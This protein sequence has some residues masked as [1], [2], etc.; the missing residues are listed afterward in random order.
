MALELKN[1][2]AKNVRASAGSRVKIRGAIWKVQR[3]EKDGAANF[4]HCLGISGI[5]KG[6]SSTFIDRLEPD[7]E[8]LK[9]ENLTLLPDTSS[10]FRDTKIYLEA[11]FRNVPPTVQESLV[12]G[13][14]AIDDLKFQHMPV[15][16]VL[17]QPR[18][19]LLIADDVGLGK[20]LEAGL[21]ASELILRHRAERILVVST[22]AMLNQF[23]REFWTRFSIPLARLDSAAIKRMHNSIPNN[24]NVF[25]Q[26]NRVIVSVDTLKRD[27]KYRVDLENSRW[28]LIIIDEAHN[29]ANRKS[30]SG[31]R[32]QRAKL[33]K[34]LAAQTDAL[35][36]LTATPHD[37]SSQ[38][39]A[40]LIEMLDPTRVPDPDS[41]KRADIEDLVVRRFR[42][43]V[44]ADFRDQV[45]PRILKPRHF[46]LSKEEDAAYEYV[47]ALKLDFD[48]EA[49]S[50]RKALHLF[51]TTLAKALF[52]S[53]MACLETVSGRLKR[54][55]SGRAKGTQADKDKLEVLRDLLE[56]IGVA[57]F[58]KY[59]NLSELLQELHWT[60]RKSKDRLVIFSERLK[61]LDWLKKQ[62]VADFSLDD[63]AIGKIDGASV[64]ADE[65][66]QQVLESFGQERSKLRILLASDMAS[67]GLNLHF[68]CHRLIHFDLPWS[69]LRFQQRNGR[70]DRYGQA[71]RPEIYYFIGK[72]TH[73]RVND[74]WVLDK[75]VEKDKQAQ[76]GIGD[77]AVFLGS[78][79]IEGEEEEV[80]AAVAKGIGEKAFEE[81][82][83]ARASKQRESLIP[84]EWG[85]LFEGYEGLENDLPNGSRATTNF[86]LPR[87]FATTFAFATDLLN[88]LSEK[89]EIQHLDV[90]PS[91]R[92]I[93]FNLPD[94]L[95]ATDAFGYSDA[96][97]VDDRYMPREALGTGKWIELT[98]DPKLVTT[99]IE[100]A[101]MSESA[102]P[103]LQYLW[104][105]HPIMQWFG[106]QAE[107][108]YTHGVAPLCDVKSE[109]ERD[110]IAVLVHGTLMNQH[111][112]V[113]R[114]LWNV[115][116]VK[117]E[118]VVRIDHDVNGFLGR[119][120]FRG[121]TPN[122][123]RA[124][125]VPSSNILEVAVQAFQKVLH[126]AR[127]AEQR[128]R[129][130]VASEIR[131][132]LTGFKYRFDEQLSLDFGDDESG[133]GTWLPV[134][135]KLGRKA[136][137]KR[138][139]EEM[140]KRWE[141]WIEANCSLDDEPYPHV[142]IKAVFR[143]GEHGV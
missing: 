131:S 24:Y 116:I 92:I 38:S 57:E 143:A 105:V 36:L 40:S 95:C 26:F 21:I 67:E 16:M 48:S 121:D 85:S 56:M 125:T 82:M 31:S 73:E 45:P 50:S 86:T 19:R 49:D 10:N 136:A 113:M 17:Q 72:S 51:R 64:E 115:I 55:A 68:Q 104:D 141:E 42:G 75:L 108:L 33:A 110:E 3:V 101:R 60:G 7:L 126:E 11:A 6:K 8:V 138:K 34:L 77:P 59:Q 37:G 139:T 118:K 84:D 13:K 140:F 132:R 114:D 61:T 66:T 14:A 103:S 27:G 91:G 93:R 9:P 98:D 97:S 89:Q 39:F 53:P 122:P 35:L 30:A 78:G 63:E 96:G 23:Q 74:M 128:R 18:V 81:Q 62:L 32:S 109:L 120:G 79:D 123:A 70:I 106:D 4:L 46:P 12:L 65:N 107:S 124:T 117:Q 119:V 58:S 83:D 47:Q 130:A 111:G 129:G 76:D 133:E 112:R 134:Q 71:M 5:V 88:R 15:K 94:S 142:D 127:L 135:A 102:W 69:L 137:A 25:D 90:N 54:M 28:D 22:R 100:Q 43:D 99:A 52:S 41:P 2:P 20:T 87:L 1:T 80:G 44:K 29:V